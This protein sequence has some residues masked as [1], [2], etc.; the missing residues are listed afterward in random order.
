MM[1]WSFAKRLKYA[2]VLMLVSA[3]VLFLLLSTGAIDV[4]FP[5]TAE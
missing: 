2:L 5:P 1:N 3:A 4:L